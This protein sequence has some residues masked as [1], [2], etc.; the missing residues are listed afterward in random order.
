VYSCINNGCIDPFFI[1]YG[2]YYN[3]KCSQYVGPEVQRLK[4]VIDFLGHDKAKLLVAKYDNKILILLLVK[5]SH[6]LNP[7][8]VSTYISIVDGPSNSSFD[9]PI[10]SVEA[11]EGLL[12][13]EFFFFG[14]CT[15]NLSDDARSPLLWWKEHARLYPNVV[16]LTQLIFAILGS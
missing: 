15:M 12:L 11:D 16:F 14:C 13:I 9:I 4:C 1:I 10:S 2:I 5:C 3:Y 8:V 6:F 7:D